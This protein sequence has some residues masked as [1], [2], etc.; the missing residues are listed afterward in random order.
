MG[1]AEAVDIGDSVFEAVD[2]ADCVFSGQPTL[3]GQPWPRDTPAGVKSERIADM[4][5][6]ISKWVDISNP[7]PSVRT[8]TKP[9]PDGSVYCQIVDDTKVRQQ[10]FRVYCVKSFRRT[11]RKLSGKKVVASVVIVGAVAGSAPFALPFHLAAIAAIG[12]AGTS[13]STVGLAVLTVLNPTKQGQ[14]LRSE[15]VEAP[16]S[17]YEGTP[18]DRPP[19]MGPWR[20]CHATDETHRECGQDG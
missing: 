9:G 17:C 4:Y 5:V 14:D 13:S 10:L 8:V 7:L 18:R 3:S 6:H 19:V 11:R 1:R 15:R 12:A 2:I 20:Q 16:Y